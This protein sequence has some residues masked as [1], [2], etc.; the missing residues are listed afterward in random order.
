MLPNVDPVARIT[1]TPRGRSLGVTQFVPDIERRNYPREFLINRM[2]VGMGGRAAEEL[3][4]DDITSGAQN[5]FQTV[6]NMARAMVTQLGMDEEIGTTYLGGIADDALGGRYYNPYEAKEYS[7]ETARAIDLAV[8]RF[9]DSAHN[10]ALQILRDNR[11]A[12]DAVAEA[13]LQD[14]SL[15]RDQFL[16]VIARHLPPGH[17]LLNGSDGQPMLIDEQ[18]RPI[19]TGISSQPN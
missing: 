3:A 7:D 11:E 10:L 18:G 5:D 15:D 19:D 17:H 8:K 12:L 1:I 6:T 2:A 14:E 9:V 4:F 13:L 16:G